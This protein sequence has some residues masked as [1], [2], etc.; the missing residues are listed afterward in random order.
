VTP[1]Q[2]SVETAIDLPAYLRRIGYAGDRA[3]TRATL[4]ALH[5]AHAT[6]IP[7]ENLDILRGVPV[8]LDLPSLESKL[9]ANRRGGYCFEQNALFATALE[10]MGFAVTRLA[11]R[12]RY[13]TDRALPRTHMTLQV[14]VDGASVLADVGFGAEGPLLPVPLGGGESRQFAWTYQ[15][16]EKDGARMLQSHRDEAWENLYAFTHEPQLPVD[17]DIA[18]YYTSTH[19]DSRFTQT[20][21]VQRSSP[22]VRRILRDREYTEDFGATAATRM[23][24]NDDELVALLASAFGLVFPVGTRFGRGRGTA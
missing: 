22:E 10:Q 11:A 4:E 17:Y 15:V 12:V 23:I 5:L 14:D 20:L 24:E 7:F 19:P 3:P 9:V 6:S 8:R 13:R 21:T 18:N 1:P 2:G 16:V